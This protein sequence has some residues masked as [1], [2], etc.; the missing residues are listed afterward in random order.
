MARERDERVKTMSPRR[1]HNASNDNQN[2]WI[3]AQ[4][5][6]AMMALVMGLNDR[7]CVYRPDS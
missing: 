4:H 1:R 5:Q 2:H 7:H 6:A 3:A